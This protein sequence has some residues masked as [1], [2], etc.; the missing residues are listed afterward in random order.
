MKETLKEIT[1]PNILL[2][3]CI[4]GII[5][6]LVL[7]YY[8]NDTLSLPIKKETTFYRAI[9]TESNTVTIIRSNVLNN[10]AYHDGDAVWVDN[11][12]T[13]NS[14]DDDTMLYVILNKVE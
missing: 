11:S 7:Q 2:A 5:S 13:I 8:T 9:S 10:N 6:L 14:V 3:F 12:E 1:N 4:G